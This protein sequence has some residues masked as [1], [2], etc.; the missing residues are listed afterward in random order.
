MTLGGPPITGKDVR[1]M[2]DEEDEYLAAF[3]RAAPTNKSVA[4]T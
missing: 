3:L 1:A 4:D 2:E